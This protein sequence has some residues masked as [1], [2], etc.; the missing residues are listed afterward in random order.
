[1]RR[2]RARTRATAPAVLATL[3]LTA[4]AGGTV[5]PGDE[6]ITATG[7]TGDDHPTGSITA[8]EESVPPAA[9]ALGA[10]T[11][12]M[13]SSAAT[14]TVPPAADEGCALTDTGVDATA[15]GPHAAVGRVQTAADPEAFYTF[16]IAEDQFNPCADLSW[17]VLEGS[18]DGTAGRGGADTSREAV[19]FFHR[20]QLIT[21]P[22]PFLVRSVAS[23]ERVDD[24][25]VRLISDR[26]DGGTLPSI[27]AWDG[28]QLSSDLTELPPEAR[29]N[30]ARIDIASPPTTPTYNLSE[31]SQTLV[32]GRYSLPI[33]DSQNLLCD[34]GQPGGPV[35]D[36]FA[37]FPTTWKMLSNQHPQATRI[38][39][40]ADPLHVRGTADPTPT[41]TRA[42]AYDPVQG[43][44][45]LQIGD[46]IVDLTEPDQATIHTPTAGF[47]ITPDSYE[48][49]EDPQS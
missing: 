36:C 34:V 45:K 33:N 39:F 24:S 14:P 1:M 19:V 18:L 28:E 38:I 26:P 25:T 27:H 47:L 22:L 44:T 37:D 4:C 7:A 41:A 16:S 30:P 6:S 42:E 20:D 29:E 23:V 13:P 49:I 48:I 9:E 11:A 2:L 43:G 10:A 35:A 40:T 31:V 17:V 21:E 5:S 12:P 15:F 3:L 32:A 46:A 8:P